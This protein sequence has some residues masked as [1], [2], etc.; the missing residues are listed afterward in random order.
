MGSLRIELS[1]HRTT[2]LI[3]AASALT[4]ASPTEINVSVH[5]DLPCSTNAQAVLVGGATL[6][7]L[8]MNAPSAASMQCVPSSDGTNALGNVVLQP[9]GDK[10]APIAFEVMI[11]PDGAPADTCNDPANAGSCIVA[12]RQLRFSPYSEIDMRVDLRL[13]CLGVVCPSGQTCDQGQCVT[14][15]TTCSGPCDDSALLP[16]GGASHFTRIAGGAAHSCAITATGGVKCWGDNSLGEIGD[17]TNTQRNAPVDVVMLNAT[18][19]SVVTGEN[20]S[21]GLT[22]A[23]TVKCWGKGDYG[24]LGNGQN[25]PSTTPVD[26]MGLSGVASIAAGCK[27]MCAALESGGVMCWGWN[28]AGQLGDGT[29]TNSNVPV[30]VQGLS[31]GVGFVTAGFH[32]SCAALSAGA[33]CWGDDTDGEL[34]D[35]FQVSQ[36]TPVA[37]TQLP[38][39]P[40]IMTGGA[41]HVFAYGV[42]DGGSGQFASF[43]A[44]PS[45]GGLMGTLTNASAGQG[46]TCALQQ[47]GALCWGDNGSGQLGRGS[48]IMTDTNAAP[49][50]GLTS[51]V[52][53]LGAGYDHACAFVGPSR[54]QCWGTNGS[55]QL[56]NNTTTASNAPVNVVNWP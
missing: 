37:S 14:A 25:N 8:A 53:D 31:S 7:T 13:S 19:I 34:G 28:D 36:T 49:V 44:N 38:F 33:K 20:F 43:G 6:D 5:T 23:R 32:S 21:C 4:C 1:R 51:G 48:S 45:T 3:A 35:G 27:H 41:Y 46:Y 55:G 2:L 17:G 16:H 29:N 26:V 15:S 10:S 47:G 12:S 11:R 22:S 52:T 9:S 50:L 30:A 39:G 24:E 42:M 56:G 54:I 18:I 40:T